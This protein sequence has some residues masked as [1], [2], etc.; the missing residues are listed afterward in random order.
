MKRKQTEATTVTAT[1]TAT[2]APEQAPGVGNLFDIEKEKLDTELNG[3]AESLR[4]SILAAGDVLRQD[5]DAETLAAELG[6]QQSVMRVLGGQINR[7]I[8]AAHKILMAT[9]EADS[10]ALHAVRVEAEAKRQAARQIG[11]QKIIEAGAFIGEDG[12]PVS[13]DALDSVL[14]DKRWFASVTE[15]NLAVEAAELLRRETGRDKE[16]FRRKAAGPE[17]KSTP[18]PSGAA[19]RAWLESAAVGKIV[20][21]SDALVEI[22]LQRPDLM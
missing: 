13:G 10:K 9:C 18:L 22:S 16:V 12:L 5:G 3:L 19:C 11:L 7:K 8:M 4:K 14:S 1:T 20:E 17:P 15:C 6:K 21:H 2:T